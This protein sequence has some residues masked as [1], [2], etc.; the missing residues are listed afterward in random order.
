MEVVATARTTASSCARSK[1][2]THG[3]HTGD[4]SRWAAQTL[5][6]KEYQSMRTPPSGVARDRGRH[7]R[8]ERQ[9]ASIKEAHA[10]IEMNPRVSR[11]SALAS[12]ATG[13]RSPNGA[14]SR[15][16]HAR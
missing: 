13:F 15:R 3:I 4:S 8:L 1:T 5:T 11:S 12:K 16:L 6:D 14:S 9:F 7:R 10:L 2:S